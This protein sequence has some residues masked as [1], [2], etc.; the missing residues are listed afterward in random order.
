ME[1]KNFDETTK[2]QIKV[3][4][5]IKSFDPILMPFES[6]A[7]YGIALASAFFGISCTIFKIFDSPVGEGNNY[8]WILLCSW[9]LFLGSLVFGGL[10]LFRTLKFRDQ[11]R[12][13]AYVLFGEKQN[14]KDRKEALNNI[15]KSYISA[16]IIESIFLVIGLSIF[17]LW[18][19][20]KI[21]NNV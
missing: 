16:V 11:M 20:L 17:I 7:K 21:K 3:G 1:E 6:M 14:E 19:L 13:F 12:K 10:E 4:E 18:V 8:D 15:K 9:S 5:F 2:N